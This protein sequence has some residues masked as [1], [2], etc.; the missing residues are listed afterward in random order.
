MS[1]L[2]IHLK[3]LPC[4]LF[5]ECPFKVIG[6]N[7]DKRLELLL[8]DTAEGLPDPLRRFVRDVIANVSV[9]LLLQWALV[10]TTAFVSKNVA[11]IMNLLF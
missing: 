10:T 7:S 2:F 4:V 3:F 8:T 5:L 6:R 1:S 11:I 9:I